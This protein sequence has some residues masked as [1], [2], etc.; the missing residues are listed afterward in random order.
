MSHDDDTDLREA[1][2]AGT[3]PAHPALAA[4][5][6]AAIVSDADSPRTRGMWIAGAAAAGLGVVVVAALL[7][8]SLSRGPSP[9]TRVV[10]AVSASALP[11]ATPSP[12]VNAQP[13]PSPTPD[14]TPAVASV[15]DG[16]TCSSAVTGGGGAQA[17]VA[18]VRVGSQQGFDR[19]VIQF[20]GPVPSY[21]VRTQPT[22]GFVHDASGEEVTLQGSAG[23]LVRVRNA[24]PSGS[25]NGPTDY[26][27]GGPV[28][29]EARQ[30]GDFEGVFSWGLGTSGPACVR[31]TVLSGPDRLVVDLVR[32]PG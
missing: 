9:V 28:L 11:D 14:A 19:L 7:A 21:E 32:S 1:F 12:A 2:A 13:P 5:V 17:A 27:L 15:P 29:A 4:R 16:F 8:A 25:Y 20:T 3:R 22:S 23:V 10:P 18:A 30:V 6:R 24:T 26:R 31:V